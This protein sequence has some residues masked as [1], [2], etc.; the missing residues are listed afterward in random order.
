M[1][2]TMFAQWI[3]RQ[4]D[5]RGWSLRHAAERGGISHTAI[6]RVANGQQ[7]PTYDVCMALARAFGL[8]PES[9]L[10]MAKLLPSAVA[11]RRIVYEANGIDRLV[12]LWRGLSVEDQ[13]RMLDLLERLQA[14]VEPRIV[15]EEAATDESG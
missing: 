9:V 4:V 1:D 5:Q 6:I 11:E 12:E 15:G 13:G 3:N 2:S 14:P 10:R 7:P 8:T